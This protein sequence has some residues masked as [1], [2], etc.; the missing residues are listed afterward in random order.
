MKITRLYLISVILFLGSIMTHVGAQQKPLQPTREQLYRALVAAKVIDPDRRLVH[1]SHTCNLRVDGGWYAVVDLQELVK[2]A[3]TPRG[4]NH[5]IVLTAGLKPIHQIDYTTER[6]LACFGAQLYVFADL[7]INNTAP[8]G[9]I[10]TF[11]RHAREISVSSMEAN[12]LPI[13]PSR[14]RKSV[15]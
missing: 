4:V 12:D 3:V 2:G 14:G 9:D 13:P 10:L 15:Q 11:T 7:A 6:P 8:S 5:I 1:L